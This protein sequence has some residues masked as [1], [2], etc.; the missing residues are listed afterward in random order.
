MQVAQLIDAALQL[1]EA[2]RRALD[3]ALYPRRFKERKPERNFV[4]IAK[5]REGLSHGQI[6]KIVGISRGAVR[7]VLRR[8]KKMGTS[9]S[10]PDGGPAL[11]EG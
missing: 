8:R 5:H 10:A 6:A 2:E 3:K 7:A 1:T 11:S 9:A 4:I